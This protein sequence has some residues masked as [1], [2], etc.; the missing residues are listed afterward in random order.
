M[1][2]RLQKTDQSMYIQWIPWI[3]TSVLIQSHAFKA[4]YVVTKAHD[5]VATVKLRKKNLFR[6]S[7]ICGNTDLQILQDRGGPSKMARQRQEREGF[8]LTRQLLRRS[9]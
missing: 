4:L 6:L 5:I 8:Q 2:H 1:N 9:Q 7:Y 3:H